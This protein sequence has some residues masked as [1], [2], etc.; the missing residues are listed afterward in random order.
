M[1][2]QDAAS[3]RCSVLRPS[4]CCAGDA[5]PVD[6]GEGACERESERERAVRECITLYNCVAVRMKACYIVLGRFKLCPIQR[7]GVGGQRPRGNIP[8]LHP[9]TG[10]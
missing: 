1:L 3:I 7:I 10:N 2:G 4:Q 5:G 9:H 6:A 8:S